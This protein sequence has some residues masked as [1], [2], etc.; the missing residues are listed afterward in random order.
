MA[1]EATPPQSSSCKA[2]DNPSQKLSKLDETDMQDTA[3]EVGTSSLVM[4][5]Y[6]P[7]HM[8]EQKQGDQLELTYSS[9]VRIRGAA[10][11]TC[12]MR[13]T[14]GR[15]GERGSGISVLMAR[16]DDDDG[17]PEIQKFLSRFNLI[18][19][20]ILF[21]FVPSQGCFFHIY[22]ERRKDGHMSILFA[23]F[24]GDQGSIPGRV[25]LKTQKMVLDTTLLNT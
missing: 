18:E 5:S 4:Y 12:W 15:E 21:F 13:W 25:I 2:T 20:L 11:R 3:G 22:K 17:N 7:L 1:L 9:S 6:E 14:I 8:A 23:N 24:P 10:L 16:Q 19:N